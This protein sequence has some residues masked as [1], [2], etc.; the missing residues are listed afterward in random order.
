[1]N[2][3]RFDKY[4]SKLLEKQKSDVQNIIKYLKFG[5]NFVER[6]GKFENLYDDINQK[7]DE[8]KDY[9]LNNSIRINK[10]GM[11]EL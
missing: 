2:Q 10:N 7:I 5:G 4:S 6:F 8:Y 9:N 11:Y 1:M 3:T